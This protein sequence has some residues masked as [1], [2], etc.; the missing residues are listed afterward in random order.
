MIE[1]RGLDPSRLRINLVGDCEHAGGSSIREMAREAGCEASLSLPGRLP[2]RE[3]LGELV[4]ADLLLLL[5]AGQP[6]QIPAKA[7]EYIAAG[8]PI[9]A[10]VE[11]G[12]TASLLAEGADADILLEPDP[13]Q[14][15]RVLQRR[16][17][18]GRASTAEPWSPPRDDNGYS[19]RAGTERLA[20][21]LD[22]T[23]A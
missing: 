22:A 9:L 15:A 14:I 6:D 8:P 20:G 1:E 7:Y 4:S 13:R 17:S 2:Y 19:R 21:L 5:A 23:A 16:M 3:A 10:L 12:A 11:P 18:N